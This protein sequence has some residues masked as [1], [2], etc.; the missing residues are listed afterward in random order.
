MSLISQ[1]S[2]LSQKFPN[3]HKNPTKATIEIKF[4]VN[5]VEDYPEK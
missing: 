4:A 2:Q 3:S 5:V 1:K